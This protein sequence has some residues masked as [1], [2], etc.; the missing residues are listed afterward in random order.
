MGQI[1]N[2]KLYLVTDIKIS[3]RNNRMAER[4]A[5]TAVD[6]TK[7]ASKI[8]KSMTAEFNAFRT[9]HETIRGNLNMLPEK[10]APVNFEYYLANVK[11][12]ALVEKF[13][14]MYAAVEVPYPED[15]ESAKIAENQAT[16]VAKIKA[17]KPFE[18]ITT[19][20]I[21]A[22]NPHIM[23]QVDAEMK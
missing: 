18:E 17:M 2:I 12:Q 8:P 11:N 7:L 10:A 6:W 20:E 23:A 22:S 19:A 21:M 9:K 15:T 1:K 4:M 13:Q 3:L 14:A 16:T 5:K